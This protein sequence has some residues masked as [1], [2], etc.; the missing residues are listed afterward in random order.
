M[1]PRFSVV[2]PTYNR[3]KA[4]LP[5]LE[6]CFKQSFD[7]FEVIVVDD[8]S[9]DDS[10]QVLSDVA[11][12]RLKV[13]SQDNAGPAAAR[14][15]GMQQAEGKYI[16]FLDSDDQWYPGFL[17]TADEMLEQHG[18]VLLYGQII[19]DRGVDRYWVKPDRA[20]DAEESIYDFLYVHGGF[21]QT[22]T[23]VVPA[24]LIS[25]VQW[26]ESVTFGDND[27]FAIDCWR[28]GIEFIM[29]PKPYTFYADIISSDALSQ[30]PIYAG[31]SE[32]YTNFFTWMATQRPYMSDMAWAGFRARFESVNVAR[33]SPLESVSLIWQGYRAGA[34]SL[35]GSAR[36]LVQ[37]MMP[38]LYRRLTDQY[39][40]MRGH[41]LDQLTG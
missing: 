25:K 17:E 2:I 18:D 1:S 8:G 27:Q 5:T 22:S 35:P 19:V 13:I 34:L 14:N 23:M 39:V 26:D 38:K 30:L 7:N 12:T 36:Q 4:I 3:S 37:N 9:T 29:M 21:I 20:L 24:S 10:L 41:T 40:R 15:L 6:S 33:Q 28:T 31:C 11:D 32:K 16:A